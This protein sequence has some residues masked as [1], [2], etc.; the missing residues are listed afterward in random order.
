MNFERIINKNNLLDESYV[1]NDLIATD[2]N[3]NNFHKF[4]DPNLKPMISKSILPYFLEMVND[5]KK[6]GLYIIIDSGYRS[7]NY[8]KTI[9]NNMIQKLGKEEALKKAAL[10]GSSE[11]QSEIGRAHV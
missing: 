4:Y 6:L 3:E 7:Y 1:P 8:Q 5:M 2:N 9:L 11:H 10:P